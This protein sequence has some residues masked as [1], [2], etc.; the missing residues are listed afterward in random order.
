MT[1]EGIAARARQGG[2]AAAARMTPE[3]RTE[4]ARKAV[5]ARWARE[6]ER[7]A[8][9]GEPPTKKTAPL[10]DDDSLAHY[11]ARVDERFGADYP[12][13]YPAD[14]KRQAL[15]LAREEAARMAAEAFGN[16]GQKN[17]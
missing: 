12:W 15:A 2:Y 10:L 4:R 3:Q 8:V 6:N 11:L 5:Q 16:T 1:D 14:R 9:A 13:K 17:A 7:R